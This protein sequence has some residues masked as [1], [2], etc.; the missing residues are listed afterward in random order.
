MNNWY[1]FFQFVPKFL[2]E[3]FMVGL[4]IASSRSSLLS[5][6]CGY[7]KIKLKYMYKQKQLAVAPN[8]QLFVRSSY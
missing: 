2:V 6:K 8:V 7:R 1:R 5:I 3:S 4:N